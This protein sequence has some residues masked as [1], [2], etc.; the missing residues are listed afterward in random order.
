MAHMLLGEILVHDGVVTPSQVEEALE[1]QVLHGGRL[2]TNLIELGHLAE[3]QLVRALGRQ[4]RVHCAHGEIAP[5]AQ[6]LALLDPGVADEKDV[7]PVRVE[8]NRLYLLVIDP[9]DIEARDYVAT[10]T[11]RWVVPVVVAEFR[12]AQLLRRHCKAFRP[13]R[14]V[15][16]EAVRKRREAAQ[17]SQVSPATDLMSEDE[18]ESLYAAAMSG[19][20]PGRVGEEEQLE[21]AL[22]VEDIPEAEVLP[23]ED[24]VEPP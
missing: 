4:H 19:Q 5:S 24:P 2:G 15:D 14:E 12:M 3:E 21:E 23:L 8:G 11:G 17:A 9:D 7:L 18:F 20:S 10:I 16:L 13:V 6:A 1:A 22:L